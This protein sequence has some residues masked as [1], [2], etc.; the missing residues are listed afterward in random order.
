M[1]VHAARFG[2]VMRNHFLHIFWNKTDRNWHIFVLETVLEHLFLFQNILS[3]FKTFFLALECPILFQNT[4]KND[5]NLLLI[6]KR[7]GC[8]VR[9][10]QIGGAHTCACTPKSGRA[11]CVR[12]TQKTVATH[13]LYCI[14]VGSMYQLGCGI[15]KMRVLKSKTFAQEFTC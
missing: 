13:A 3:C 14:Y 2:R 5:E 9:P 10:P 8:K 7:C 11:R 4:L 15:S 6:Q 12:A 1:C